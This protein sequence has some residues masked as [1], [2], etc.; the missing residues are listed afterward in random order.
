MDTD[1]SK[2]IAVLNALKENFK[3]GHSYLD[4]ALNEA[5]KIFES[6]NSTDDDIDVFLIVTDGY[7][8]LPLYFSP[9]FL[10]FV[11]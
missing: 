9:F 8:N 2:A 11:S 6:K 10:V 7:D 1:S 4:A 5:S 3:D